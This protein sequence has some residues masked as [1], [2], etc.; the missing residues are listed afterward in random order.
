MNLSRSRTLGNIKAEIYNYS[1]IE[2]AYVRFEYRK[3]VTNSYYDLFKRIFIIITL[4]F[5]EKFLT[6]INKNGGSRRHL[7]GLHKKIIGLISVMY[8]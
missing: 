6:V 3:K 8:I 7:Y 1:S 4:L 5:S 2:V